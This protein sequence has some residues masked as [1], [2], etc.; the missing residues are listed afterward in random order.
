PEEIQLLYPVDGSSGLLSV[1]C[2]G[3][4]CGAARRSGI[5]CAR[6]AVV[7]T[8]MQRRRANV[9]AVSF[10][11]IDLR[12]RTE[13]SMGSGW[14][15]RMNCHGQRFRGQQAGLDARGH[16][17]SFASWPSP[18]DMRGAPTSLTRNNGCHRSDSPRQRLEPDLFAETDTETLR[19]GRVA[20]WRGERQL[21]SAVP[22]S[23]VAVRDVELLSSCC[24]VDE[25]NPVLV[26]LT[27]VN[28]KQPP[29]RCPI[30]HF[31]RCRR[32]RRLPFSVGFVSASDAVRS[33]M[34]AT[35]AAF[36]LASAC[37]SVDSG[38]GKITAVKRLNR[39]GAARYTFQVV[40]LL[41]A[42]ARFGRPQSRRCPAGGCQRQSPE[43]AD[44]G[45]SECDRGPAGADTLVTMVT[46]SDPD[47][48]LNATVGFRLI[49]TEVAAMFYL[50][51]PDETSQLAPAN[52]SVKTLGKLDY[53]TKS[54]YNLI[55][56]AYDLGNP[57]LLVHR[58]SVGD[59]SSAS[60]AACPDLS[61]QSGFRY[62]GVSTSASSTGVAFNY[63][64]GSSPA[65]VVQHPTACWAAAGPGVHPHGDK[66]GDSSRQ[67]KPQ[68]TLASCGCWPPS[69]A[70]FPG[71][72][73]SVSHLAR[74]QRP[75]RLVAGA[76]TLIYDFQHHDED[77]GPHRCSISID[78]LP[79]IG[80]WLRRVLEL[81]GRQRHSCTL[82]VSLDS[83]SAAN[84]S[85][86]CQGDAAGLPQPAGAAAGAAW[87][88]R[89]RVS[90]SATD[91]PY[92]SRLVIGLSGL[93]QLV[94]HLAGE[95]GG[96]W[97][98]PLTKT[99]RPHSIFAD[100][101]DDRFISDSVSGQA[102]AQKVIFFA[103]P[104]HDA[105][106]C[107]AQTAAFC[108][109]LRTCWVQPVT[110]LHFRLVLT[111]GYCAGTNSASTKSSWIPDEFVGL[112]WSASAEFEKLREAVS[113]SGAS[114]P[115]WTP[116]RRARY[117]TPTTEHG[118]LLLTQAR[119]CAPELR[120]KRAEIVAFLRLGSAATFDGVPF[121]VGR[122]A[123]TL[124]TTTATRLC[125]ANARTEL[126]R[127]GPSSFS[128]R[129]KR[130]LAAAGP[131]KAS[132]GA[133]G[134]KA[135]GSTNRLPRH[136]GPL[137]AIYQANNPA[138]IGAQIDVVGNKPGAC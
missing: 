64:L 103:Q 132:V 27:D 129:R 25:V 105:C 24:L 49:Q 104:G 13:E 102:C 7:V 23:S 50:Q 41:T 44:V 37:S 30:L 14:L 52:V 48:G 123:S 2:V 84:Y 87:P 122:T 71:G 75:P 117:C 39:D 118:R 126:G 135:N 12:F 22:L 97:Y 18:R 3:C 67:R 70:V 19:P 36:F 101:R 119:P 120:P 114:T 46:A 31:C 68:T 15:G 17:L 28:D 90:D 40:A 128:G 29:V 108:N 55:L 65:P 69:R 107:Q 59:R 16:F 33:A 85:L 91:Q 98:R 81:D 127:G 10:T 45:L 137:A 77:D 79:R 78:I 110:G 100:E 20:G 83:E 66:A 4:G 74:E 43:F 72:P 6:S 121:A 54:L 63:S 76:G 9:P 96:W 80:S 62:A 133:S 115:R 32:A 42:V 138:Q 86:S 51:Q 34:A 73:G 130:I 124:T 88:G 8:D 134:L 109:R 113:E 21:L 89:R 136:T 116:P 112:L 11:L 57:S 38:T 106:A 61:G 56:I 5:F 131:R 111:A 60:I 99:Q 94:L 125:C 58:H 82:K 95:D 35:A 26:T 1:E 93:K 47:I 53:A 92:V